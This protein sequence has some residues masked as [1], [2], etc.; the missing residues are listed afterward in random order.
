MRSGHHA[1][2]NWITSQL[3]GTHVFINDILNT[4]EELT[5][6]PDYYIYNLED[7]SLK[8][9]N[10]LRKDER[11]NIGDEII[12]ILVLR[13]AYN[14]FASRLTHAQREHQDFSYSYSRIGWGSTLAINLW[15]EHT[16]EF[17][18]K[19]KYL[20]NP[21]LLNFNFWFGSIKF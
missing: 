15:K 20:K 17:L 10:K 7:F 12:E 11:F 2:I 16:K 21:V 18:R 13:D 5:S 9:I 1:V 14:L 19:T 6:A 8:N 4:D 3:D